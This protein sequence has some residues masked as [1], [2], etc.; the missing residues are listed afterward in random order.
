MPRAQ[1]YSPQLRREVVSRLY[2]LAKVERVPMTR[3]VDQVVN[4]ALAWHGPELAGTLRVGGGDPASSV[5]ALARRPLSSRLVQ[6]LRSRPS[7]LRHGRFWAGA[8]AA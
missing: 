1:W 4:E 3:L 5:A 6:L 7:T 8:E 2:H